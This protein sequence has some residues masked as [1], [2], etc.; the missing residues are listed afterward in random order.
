LS[1]AVAED[2]WEHDAYRSSA[3]AELWQALRAEVETAGLGDNDVWDLVAYVWARA[4]PPE[5]RAEGEA[6]YAVHCAACHGENGAG[7]G[8]MA[9]VLKTHLEMAEMAFGS[10]TVA[11]ADFTDTATMLGASPALLQ[12]KLIR[13]GMGT[14]M[15]AWGPI[16]TEAQTW[17]VVGY[18]YGFVF[19]E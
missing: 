7:D 8:V 3:P 15:P 11:P 17:A 4:T 10:H 16:L 6:V 19:D 5:A 12:G 13:G 14:G 2:Y 1:Q 18:L 9:R